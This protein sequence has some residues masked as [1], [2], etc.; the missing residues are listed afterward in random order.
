MRT[1]EKTTALPE[2]MASGV[3]IEMHDGM[4][5]WV[6]Q[7]VFL[8]WYRRP[9]PGVGD[10]VCFK[11]EQGPRTGQKVFGRVESRQFEVQRDDEGETSLW[12]R[13][14]LEEIPAPL[15]RTVPRRSVPENIRFTAN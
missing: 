1:Q 7:A 11:A 13:L 6:A 2:A 15:P 4:G 14:E 12:V 9:V 3:F 8:D 5:Q 10:T